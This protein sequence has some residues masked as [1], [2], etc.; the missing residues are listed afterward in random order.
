MAAKEVNMMMNRYE[1]V[2]QYFTGGDRGIC[3]GCDHFL[4][5]RLHTE[6][7]KVVQFCEEFSCETAGLPYD[8]SETYALPGSYEGQF[9]VRKPEHARSS[10][11]GL[12]KACMKL[13]TCAFLKPGGGTWDCREYEERSEK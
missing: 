1:G 4:K 7:E 12:C 3:L 5:C 6:K 13:L 8:R 11:I 10:Y 2:S 9:A